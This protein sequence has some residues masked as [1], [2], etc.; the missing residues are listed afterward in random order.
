MLN[1]DWG[2]S[3]LVQTRLLASGILGAALC[4]MA[5]RVGLTLVD[6]W[7]YLLPWLHPGPPPSAETYT[8]EQYNKYQDWCQLAAALA[9]AGNLR[10]SSRV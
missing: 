5:L 8:L 3:C 10:H 1:V 7:K 9:Q 4:T 2:S 6:V